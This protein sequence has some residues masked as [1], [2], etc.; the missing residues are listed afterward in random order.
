[1]KRIG[2]AA[3]AL[4]LFAGSAAQADTFDLTFTSA[5]SQAAGNI[6]GVS[7]SATLTGTLLSSVGGVNTYDITS[8]SGITLTTPDGAAG[9]GFAFAANPNAPN[10]S[11]S[12]S[13]LLNYDDLLTV[14][15]GNVELSQYGLLFIGATD[16]MEVNVFSDQFVPTNTTQYNDSNGGV[17]ELYTTI[18]DLTP[19]PEPLTL[20]LLASGLVALGAARRRRSV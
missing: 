9:Q 4:M 5:S 17:S 12:P 19:V 2:I 3:A 6:T 16:A 1:M 10:T 15:G 20:T 14:S 11:T 13:T 8:A 18:T 7:G